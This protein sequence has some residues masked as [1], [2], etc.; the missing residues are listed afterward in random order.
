MLDVA[1][2]NTLSIEI[3]MRI[4]IPPPLTC[5]SSEESVDSASFPFGDLRADLAYILTTT[6]P[7]RSSAMLPYDFVEL[8][9]IASRPAGILLA[10]SIKKT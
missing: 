8:I 1:K 3:F 10:A 2:G 5:R 9:G 7:V 6:A 4:R